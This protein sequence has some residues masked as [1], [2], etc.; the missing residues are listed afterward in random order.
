MSDGGVEKWA[1]AHPPDRTLALQFGE[2]SKRFL[3]GN[4][5]IPTNGTS[6]GWLA[7]WGP[8]QCCN[9]TKTNSKLIM[10]IVGGS[11]IAD[12]GGGI[13]VDKGAWD[14]DRTPNVISQRGETTA[15]R[16]MQW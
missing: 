2:R 10:M 7:G 14:D 5:L 1:V 15:I 16:E 8:K 13:D 3:S 6:A 12:G 9:E 4:H 11:G